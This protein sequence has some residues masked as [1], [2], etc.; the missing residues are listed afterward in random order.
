M[1]IVSAAHASKITLAIF[2]GVVI[3]FIVTPA[4]VV[5]PMS[6]S[7][8]MAFELLPSTP[9]FGQY[10]RIWTNPDW[11]IS[12]LYS[13]RIALG[14]M[15]LSSTLGTLAS[16]G[17]SKLRPSNQR[18]FQGLLLA[19]YIVPTVVYAVAAY[20]VF[21]KFGL[22][23]TAIGMTIAHSVIALPIVIVLVGSALS[24]LDPTL[25]EA[26]MSLGASPARTFVRITFPQI[27][28][29]I[30]ASAL[31][32]FHVSF[33]EVV[34]SLFLSGSN[35]LTLPVKIWSSIS[36]ETTPILPAISTIIIVISLAVITPAL[37]FGGFKGSQAQKI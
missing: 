22:V 29:A 20:F 3:A 2:A 5:I 14:V 37:L 9:S 28:L 24:S 26:S 16:L 31:F 36:Y 7:S 15:L 6:F 25:E 10:Q 33:D 34:V 12:F 35:V 21:S 1:T 18:I 30:L 4:V 13:L 17:L 11:T 19:P 27:R 23:G 8:S 32:S